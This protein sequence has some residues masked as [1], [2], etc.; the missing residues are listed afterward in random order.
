[1]NLR[2]PAATRRADRLLMVNSRSVPPKNITP[3]PLP[4]R[5][6]PL[7]SSRTFSRTRC[8][9]A[10]G[11]FTVIW[12]ATVTSPVKTMMSSALGP[13]ASPATQLLPAG[14]AL[15]SAEEK[16]C[17][18][19]QPVSTRM[20]AASAGRSTSR[21]YQT[22]NIN[23]KHVLLTN[24]PRSLSVISDFPIWLNLNIVSECVT[25]FYYCRHRQRMQDDTLFSAAP[26]GYTCLT[27]RRD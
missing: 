16:A 11:A 6:C 25:P 14:T 1:M 19:V 21:N 2:S 24:T 4:R 27:V 3:L 23:N 18:S 26:R 15:L 17:A 7:P 13:V 10:P 5:L 8:S 20:V 12:L 22:T 9:L